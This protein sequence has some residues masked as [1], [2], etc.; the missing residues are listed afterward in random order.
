[1]PAS[2]VTGRDLVE[3]FADSLVAQGY[4]HDTVRGFRNSCR[5]L[6]VWLYRSELTLG[7]IDDGVL[8][9]FLDHRCDL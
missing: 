6:V 3:A 5:H 9:R 7:E 1:M 2:I 8:Q 4:R